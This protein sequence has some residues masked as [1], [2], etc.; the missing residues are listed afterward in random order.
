MFETLTCGVAINWIAYRQ[1]IKLPERGESWEISGI[2]HSESVVYN[3]ALE[4]KNLVDLMDDLKKSW[5][6]R[7]TSTLA[8]SNGIW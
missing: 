2:P 4:G 7:V 5:L 8:K 1:S 3:G 6:A